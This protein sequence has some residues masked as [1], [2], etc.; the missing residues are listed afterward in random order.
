MHT[1]RDFLRD[2]A[3]ARLADRLRDRYHYLNPIDLRQGVENAHLADEGAREMQVLLVCLDEIERSRPFFIGLLGDRYGWIPPTQRIAAAARAAGLP[4]SANVA[5]KSVTELEILHAVLENKN[6]MNRSWFYFRNLDRSTMPPEIAVRF[7]TEAESSDPASPAAKLQ[8]LK[9]R[10]RK[11]L[12]DRVRNYTLRWDQ[13]KQSM[14]GLESLDALVEADIWSD[15]DPETISYLREAPQT[16]QEADTRAVA[17]FVAERIRGYVER[18][19]V[20]TPM[21]DHALSPEASGANWGLVV[22]GEPGGGKSSFFSTVFYTL[23]P[24]AEAGEILLLAHAAGVFPLSGQVDR[25]L[26]RWVGELAVFL[27]IADPLDEV[28]YSAP[29]LADETG[30]KESTIITSEDIEKTFASLLSRAAAQRRVVLLIDALTQFETTIRASHLTWLPRSFPANVRLLA[31]AIPG[32]ASTALQ[33]RPGASELTV[34]PVSRDEA[35]AIAEKFYRERHHREV[36]PKVLDALLDKQDSGRPAHA[37]PLW[38]VLALQE[39][40][41]LEADDFERAD[42]DYAHLR[43]A[44]RLTALQVDEANK[45]PG[46]VSGAYGEL[47]DR[48]E[49]L[50]GRAWTR[51]FTDL[52]AL[53]RAGWR[54]SDLQLLMPL[55]SGVPWDNL[56][57]ANLRRTLGSHVVQRGSQA[58]WDFFHGTLRQTILHRN[59]SDKGEQ[60]WL[61][62][63]LA[64]HLQSLPPSD[65]LFQS[66]T[67]VHL[68]GFEDRDRA[69]E[70]LAELANSK[71]SDSALAAALDGTITVLVEAFQA[72]PDSATRGKLAGWLVALMDG[73]DAERSGRVA[74]V[75]LFEV[76]KALAVTGTREMKVMRSQ[77]LHAA[78]ETMERLAAVDPSNAVWQRDLSMS[79]LKIG[80]VLRTQG[81]LAGALD[82]YQESLAIRQRLAAV[83]PNSALLQLDISVSQ[84][85]IGSVLRDQG[86]LP[87]AMDF[88]QKSLAAAEHFMVADSNNPTRLTN[89]SICKDRIGDILRTQGDLAGALNSYRESLAIRQRLAAVKPSNALLQLGISVSRIKIGDVLY[90]QGDLDRALDLY[91]E[92]LALRECLAAADPRNVEWLRERSVSQDRIGDV[93]RDQ[94]DLAGALHAYKESLA[95]RKRL[96]TLDSENPDWQKGLSVSQEKIGSVL[97]DQGDLAGALHAY[98]EALSARERLVDLHPKNV[99]LQ[100]GLS[101]SQDRIGSV[102]RDQGDLA[103][104]LDAYKESLAALGRLVAVDSTNAI[105]QRGFSNCQEVIGDV[106]RDQ[107]K[108]AKAL[109]AYKESLTVRE[110]LIIVNPSNTGWQFE[111]SVNQIKIGDTLLDQGNLAKALEFYRSSLAIRK[112]LVAADPNILERQRELS[113]SQERIGDVLRSQGDLAGALNLYQESLAVRKRLVAE[114]PSNADWQLGLS[115][116]QERIG[117]ILFDQGRLNLAMSLYKESLGVRKRI[118]AT[119]PSNA[120]LQRCISIIKERIGNVLLGQGD[121][122]GAFVFYQESLAITERLLA[123]DP[124]NA[125]RQRDIFAVYWRMAQVSGNSNLSEARVWYQKAYAILFIMKQRGTMAPADEQYLSIL[126]EKASAH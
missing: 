124:N 40:N 64:D 20:T 24:R 94:G 1:E 29:E 44:S 84:E 97:R 115:V 38:L 7:P 26:R 102:L 91:R 88:Y 67:M 69:A 71:W 105:W 104:A 92:S 6:Q 25:M 113:I 87:C 70:F 60:R 42:R 13:E 85:R 110:R 9:N 83:E 31:T 76:N 122:T 80:D 4:K 43:E 89:I 61:H 86:N 75:F 15:L 58:Q 19:A 99:D 51:S 46:D 63:L 101:A 14:I 54:E 17:D 28:K 79:H 62:G 23:K 100:F 41:L 107:G 126:I 72:A 82:S 47:L 95:G 27:G 48:A 90:T 114:N 103:G 120:E 108:Q 52:T 93:L 96:L 98:K 111:I 55:A 16:W 35:R 2:H 73:E 33:E 112:R 39:M 118:E 34:P 68:L 53:S 45:L 57:F 81:D 119:Y 30:P 109:D 106:L 117:D 18:L 22:T 37:N 74:N 12:P 50:Y 8:A 116:S 21:F 77:L 11:Q 36:N 123:V 3:L 65:L 10:I 56:A 59:L 49:R 78:R 121:L 125:E 32:I 66:E 5:G